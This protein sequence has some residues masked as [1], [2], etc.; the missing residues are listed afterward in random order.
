[1]VPEKILNSYLNDKKLAWAKTT[2]RGT[3]MTLR[4]LLPILDGDPHKL[5][6]YLLEKQKPYSR[7]TT[8]LRVCC[9]WDFYL[10]SL[11]GGIENV[12]NQNPYRKFRTKNSRLFK[13]KYVKK[14]PRMGIAFARKLIE[15]ELASHPAMCKKALE[16]LL[17][18]MRWSESFTLKEGR[19]IGKGELVREVIVPNVEGPKYHGGY[20]HF[21]RTLKAATGFKPHDL[22]K[23]HLNECV[24]KGANAFDLKEIA[25]WKNITTAMS[26]IETDPKRRMEISKLVESESIKK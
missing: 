14:I 18:G 9:F 20:L 17:S 21:Y 12:K 13:N 25:G 19:V 2:L 4:P 1:M 23:I 3:K 11:G 22:R 10:A 7:V 16:L 5:W 26:Y 15:R 24:K 6:D 8:W